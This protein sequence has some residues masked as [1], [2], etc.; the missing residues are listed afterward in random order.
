MA[1]PQLSFFNSRGRAEIARLILE[2]HGSRC[3]FVTVEPKDWPQV[4]DEHPFNDSALESFASLKMLK[5]RMESRPLMKAYLCH[6][7]GWKPYSV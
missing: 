4:R 1:A 7:D 5:Q 6:E 3:E 2:D